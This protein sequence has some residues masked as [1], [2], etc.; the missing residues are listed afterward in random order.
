MAVEPLV[1]FTPSGRRGRFAAGTTVLDAARSLG[2]DIDSV[3]GGRGICGRCQVT[4]GLGEF[5]KH[6]ITSSPDHLS[7]FAELEAAYREEK[8]LAA[9]RRLS[10][11][12]TV[13]GDVVIDVPPESQVHR[14]VVRKGLDVR[15][16]EVDPVV[17]LHYVEVVPPELASPTGDL[18]R[19]FEAL[20]RE[21]QLTGLEADLEVVRALQ[22]AL[23]AGKYRVTVAV[24]EGRQ[25]IAVWPGLHDKAYGVAID[26]GSTTIAGHLADL[27]DGSVLASNGVMNPQIRF[28]EDLMSRVSYAMM[29]P[30]GAGEMTA[31]VRKA[32]DGLIA[33][34]AMRAGIK[35]VDILELTIVG[36]PI[37]HHLVL[38]IDPMPLGGAPF[39]LATDR[40]GQDDHRRT[41]AA[42]PR[43][44]P[45]STCCPASP[46]TSAPTRPA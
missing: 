6:G 36:N 1:I 9:D 33:T 18:A 12:A 5:P 2:V 43:R 28:G 14:Q 29:H 32:L 41:R 34:L 40:R 4:Q 10:C 46:A 8:G 42:R 38:G 15:D 26:V 44:A 24:H 3:C 39:A 22:P 27:A 45:A 16:F 35:R 21:W 17:R 37:M 13:C 19:L 31:A 20:E 30:E 23:E 7:P 25:V 11:T